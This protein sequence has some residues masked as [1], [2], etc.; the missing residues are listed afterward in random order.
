MDGLLPLFT[1]KLTFKG[2]DIVPISCKIT[3]PMPKVPDFIHAV[4]YEGYALSESMLLSSFQ[5][6]NEDGAVAVLTPYQGQL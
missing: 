5:S 4:F 1:V 3:L 2:L 6:F